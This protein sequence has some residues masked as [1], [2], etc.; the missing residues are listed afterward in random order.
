MH[1]LEHGKRN[2]MCNSKTTQ[3]EII[4]ILA[5][6]IRKKTTEILQSSSAVFSIIVRL[7][8]K[9]ADKEILAVCLRFVSYDEIQELFL[10]FVELKRASG[11]HIAQAILQ[12]LK[13][14]T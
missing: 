7:L 5:S 10:D 9:H 1:H 13:R 3:N 2:A 8:I 4:D 6:Y 14:I 11:A 12:S